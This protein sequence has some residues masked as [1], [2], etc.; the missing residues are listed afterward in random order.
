[1]APLKLAT[2]NINLSSSS[3]TDGSL[4]RGIGTFQGERVVVEVSAMEKKADKPR[5]A[6][7]I[8]P[9]SLKTRSCRSTL[10]SPAPPAFSA[11]ADLDY[12]TAFSPLRYGFGYGWYGL[13]MQVSEVDAPERNVLGSFENS[14]IPENPRT[15]PISYISQT[16]IP[17]KKPTS[18]LSKTVLQVG[19][20]FAIATHKIVSVFGIDTKKISNQMRPYICPTTVELVV[21]SIFQNRKVYTSKTKVEEMFS[22]SLVQISRSLKAHSIPFKVKYSMIRKGNEFVL[23]ELYS[24]WESVVNDSCTVWKQEHTGIGLTWAFRFRAGSQR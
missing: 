17:F 5:S 6:A 15:P 10:L 20:P 14:Y 8:K 23:H 16:V 21:K 11:I 13:G 1:M 3:V 2:L 19:Q 9:C 18:G 4:I 24:H 12:C 22:G 7:K